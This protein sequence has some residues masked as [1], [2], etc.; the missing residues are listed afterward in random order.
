MKSE[1]FLDEGIGSWAKGKLARTGLLGRTQFYKQS[2]I[3]QRS[4]FVL[5]F[6]TRL[7]LAFKSALQNQELGESIDL[8]TVKTYQKFDKLVESLLTEAPVKT[9]KEWIT[10]QI[11]SQ[12]SSYKISPQN[13]QIF[14]NLTTEFETAFNTDKT[15]FPKQVAT[16]IANWVYNVGSTQTRDDR[17][18]VAAGGGLSA[19]SQ[20]P[21]TGPTVASTYNYP[22]VPQGQTSTSVTILGHV[23][24]Y[25]PSTTQGQPGEWKNDQNQKFVDSA[26]I[27]K[28]NKAWYEAQAAAS[29]APPAAAPA[30]APA[31]AP[32]PAPAG[33]TTP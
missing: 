3:D 18:R 24:T 15:K 28:L 4:D 19:A 14:D 7:E 5:D 23:Y 20:T 8:S 13:K 1:E 32:S 22:T 12:V 29:A 33:R 9:P 25:T 21:P 6:V 10:D 31:R 27:E 17:G 16:K 11:E 26:S 30:P 2:V